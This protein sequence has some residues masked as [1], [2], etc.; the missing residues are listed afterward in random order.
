MRSVYL[1]A[2]RDYLGYVTSIGFWIGMLLTPLLMG[3]GA[4]APGFIDSATSVRYFAVIEDGNTFTAELDKQLKG[5]LFDRSNAKV[6][7]VEVPISNSEDISD[8]MLSGTP[9]DG[10]EGPKPVETIVYVSA[11]GRRVEYW[12]ENAGGGIE[13]EIEETIT[14]LSQR[15]VFSQAGVDLDILKQAERAEAKFIKKIPR[16][17]EE[18]GARNRTLEDE[19]PRL[20][21]ILIAFFLWVMIFS[22]VNY[23]LMGTIEERANKIFDTLLTSVKL[24]QLLAGKLLA[25]LGVSV[26]L[27][28]FWLIGGTL[29]TSFVSSSLSPEIVGGIL[30]AVSEVLKPGI[31]IPALLSFV[32]GYLM[33]GALFLAV[34]SLCDTV[35]EAQTL[36]TPLL[37]LLMAPLAIGA[38]SIENPS[39]SLVQMMTW[40]PLF[41]PFLLILRMPINPPLWEVVAQLGLMVVTTILIL[42]L[43]TRI[44]RAG[45]VNGA[46]ISDVSAWFTR[47]LPGRKKS[48]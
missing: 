11:D 17:V 43:A 21:S 37:I 7:R 28:S 29:F 8:F 36:M 47:F 38:I 4:M 48:V 26:T 23:L 6:F 12:Q 33:Y 40:V 10:P 16:S 32:L 3:L 25:V 15:A 9:V 45:V 22:V 13:S 1:V 18:G 20:V 34:G 44:Y 30:T 42:W 14:L 39:S 24:P 31:V 35:Q 41:T 19:I 27:T 5:G 2:R 46:G